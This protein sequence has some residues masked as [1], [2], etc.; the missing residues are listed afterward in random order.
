MSDRW[1]YFLVLKK[2]LHF[3][4]TDW[5]ANFL[6]MGFVFIFTFKMQ[7][8][9]CSSWITFTKEIHLTFI[10]RNLLS[11][12]WF[13]VS[14]LPPHSC[15]SLS[16]R[17]VCNFCMSPDAMLRAR[18]EILFSLLIWRNTASYRVK[19]LMVRATTEHIIS[20]S[21]VQILS[22]FGALNTM[23]QISVYLLKL[24]IYHETAFYWDGGEWITDTLVTFFILKQ[25]FQ[26]VPGY[27]SQL[28]ESYQAFH[29]MVH[30]RCPFPTC[31]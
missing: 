22:K 21:L 6:R 18:V 29:L 23:K 26:C 20:A 8:R 31:F 3:S 17:N 28:S 5:K 14:Y 10:C 9:L 15:L 25:P 19:L 1:K 30:F 2:E 12:H 13:W 27:V 16:H 11:F 24:Q 4:Y 7:I